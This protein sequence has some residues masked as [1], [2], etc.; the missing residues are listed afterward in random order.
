VLHQVLGPIG[1]LDLVRNPDVIAHNAGSLGDR[2]PGLRVDPPRQEVGDPTVGVRIASG[3]DVGPHT[4]GRAVAAD[5]VEELMRREMG[6]LVKADQ[7]NLSALPVVDRGVK[8]Q[9][10]KLDLAAA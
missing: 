9:V 7:R 1:P 10:R 8:L 2:Q 3:T 4:T 5:H 6:Q